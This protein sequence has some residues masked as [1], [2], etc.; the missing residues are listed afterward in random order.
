MDMEKARSIFRSHPGEANRLAN[1]MGVSRQL[2]YMLLS[3]ERKGT[4]VVGARALVAIFKRAAELGREQKGSGK[5]RR[6]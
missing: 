3:G 6:N 5:P 2:V 4:G 1:K